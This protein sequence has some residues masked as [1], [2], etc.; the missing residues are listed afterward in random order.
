MI[1]K[2]G[3]KKIGS[4]VGGGIGTMFGCPQVGVIIG[5]MVGGMIGTYVD[6]GAPEEFWLDAN[7]DHITQAAEDIREIGYALTDIW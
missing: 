2:A 5:N 4:L 1:I 3:C 6:T 7:C